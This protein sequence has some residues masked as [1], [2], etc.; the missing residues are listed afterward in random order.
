[1]STQNS[2]R[3]CPECPGTYELVPPTE[4]E[5]NT[6]REKPTSDDYRKR[7]YECDDE[8]HLI[9]VYWEKEKFFT[10]SQKTATEREGVSR[11]RP[12]GFAD[13]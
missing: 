7:V 5:Y 2:K 4:L 13:F 8:R 11:F 12:S 3:S 1:M 6:P 9:T 10:A